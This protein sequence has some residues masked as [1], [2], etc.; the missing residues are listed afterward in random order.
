[1]VVQTFKQHLSPGEQRHA[2]ANIGAGVDL[3]V[4][5]DLTEDQK[6]RILINLGLE[7]EPTLPQIGPS[8]A[9][10]LTT[11]SAGTTIVNLTGVPTG[12]TPT[13][14]PTDPGDAGKIAVVGTG[15]SAHL[16]VGSTPSTDGDN[17]SGTVAAAGALSRNITITANAPA[18][19]TRPRYGIGAANAYQSGNVAALF[20]SMTNIAG[21]SNG[22]K[23]GGPFTVAPGAGQYGWVAIL[24]SAAAGGVTFNDGL[25]DG[26]WSGAGQ[27][28]NFTSGPLTPSTS[29]TSYTDA[30]DNV[31]LLFRQDYS[32]A[33][34]TGSIS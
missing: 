9:T 11:A 7:D 1:V 8:S 19:N 30:N 20:A 13:F 6:L 14:T 23:T 32:N 3:T 12:V 27:A 28:G 15:G 4:P 25:G 21:S 22:G 26:G 5:Q 24:Q 2:R 34:F 10:F 18:V 16:V 17:V 33:A 31:W 29:S